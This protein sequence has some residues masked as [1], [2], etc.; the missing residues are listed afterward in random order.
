MEEKVIEKQL[1]QICNLN[2]TNRKV[3]VQD[4]LNLW[5]EIPQRNVGIIRCI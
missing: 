1:R 3:L 4:M 2:W 5:N